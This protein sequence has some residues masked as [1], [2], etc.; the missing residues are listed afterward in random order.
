[1]TLTYLIE[2]TNIMLWLDHEPLNLC[3]DFYEGNTSANGTWVHTSE[4]Q[5]LLFEY[6]CR[7]ISSHLFHHSEKLHKD[8]SLI[9]F[10]LMHRFQACRNTCLQRSIVSECGCG[11]LTLENIGSSVPIICEGQNLSQGI[12]PAIIHG[13]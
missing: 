2:S 10:V 13:F 12:F 6:V 8:I 5:E 1:M 7:Q 9:Y 4:C 3:Y 11:D